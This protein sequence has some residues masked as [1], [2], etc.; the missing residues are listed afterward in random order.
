M[1]SS[2]PDNYVQGQSKTPCIF[3]VRPVAN[4]ILNAESAPLVTYRLNVLPSKDVSLHVTPS[5]FLE[6]S[7]LES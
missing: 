3:Q 2:N 7:N 4:L 5:E 6:M 1:A